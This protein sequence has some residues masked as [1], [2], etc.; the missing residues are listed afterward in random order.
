MMMLCG[1][2]VFSGPGSRVGT[3]RLILSRAWAC[4]GPG[5][6]GV[7]GR[8]GCHCRRLGRATS[9][10]TNLAQSQRWNVGVGTGEFSW[11]YPLPAALGAAGCGAVFGGWV[12]VGQRRRD[13]GCGELA[14]V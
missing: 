9:S 3:S 1:L 2:V 10:A 6:W 7:R 14:A 8:S 12:F 11:S 13:D 4:A 5:A